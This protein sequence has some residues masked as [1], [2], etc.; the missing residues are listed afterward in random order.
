M[1]ADLGSTTQAKAETIVLSA[2][3]KGNLLTVALRPA[4]IFGCVESR[5]STAQNL[6]TRHRRS[7]GDRQALPGVLDVLKSGKTNFQIGDNKNLFD[8]TYVDNVVHAHLIASERLEASVPFDSLDTRLPPVDKDLPRRLL[9]TSTYRPPSL[10]ALEQAADPSFTNTSSPDEPLY[11]ARNRY[12][13]FYPR[14]P[15]V[16]RPEDLTVAGQAFFITNGEPIPFWDFPRAVWAA[17]NGH[18]PSFVIPLPVSIGL[19]AAG[20]A[21]AFSWIMGR[22]PGLTRGK[23]VYSTVHRYYNIE[24]VRFLRALEG[25]DSELILLVCRLA[26]CWGTNRLSACKKVSSELS[27][28][29][30][31]LGRRFGQE[32]TP[33]SLAVVQGERSRLRCHCDQSLNLLSFSWIP[34]I[35]LVNLCSF[36]PAK[37]TWLRKRLGRT[38][39]AP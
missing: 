4:G 36:F 3:G 21:E 5:S 12:D 39:P 38:K 37:T 29:V 13:Q 35:P 7:P 2:N 34:F 19:A 16:H 1:G 26:E 20:G 6:T 8:W 33:T 17:Y 11:A 14:N 9:P 23:V 22:T 10:L 24:K 27:L 18:E 31:F 32:L 28:C 30:P 15:A 25:E